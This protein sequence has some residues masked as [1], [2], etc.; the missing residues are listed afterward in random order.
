MSL[1]RFLPPLL[2]G[3]VFVANGPDFPARSPQYSFLVFGPQAQNRVCVV[4]DGTDLY[5]DKTGTGDL[6]A[7]LH[8][9]NDG[10][11]FQPFEI[12]DQAGPDHYRVTSLRVERNPAERRAFLMAN[13]EVK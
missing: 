3:V 2:A 11:D 12:A 5:V 1:G 4:L 10:K 9:P 13:V 7:A 8:F 6:A